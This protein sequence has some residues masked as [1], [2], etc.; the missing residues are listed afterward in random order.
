MSNTHAQV[1]IVDA[2]K[3]NFEDRITKVVNEIL[4][5]DT[6][7]HITLEEVRMSSPEKIDF[8][9]IFRHYFQDDTNSANKGSIK[10]FRD[11]VYNT[12][13]PIKERWELL[14]PVYESVRSTGYGRIPLIIARDLYGISDINDATIGELTKRIQDANKPGLYKY[15]LKDKAK[16]DLAIMDMGHNKYD[17]EYFRHVEKFDHFVF[18]NSYAELKDLGVQYDI[19]INSMSDY[20]AALRKAFKEGIDFGMVGVKSALA[21]PRILKFDNVS[22]TRA[23]KILTALLNKSDVNGSDIKALQDYFMHRVLDL[24]DEFDIPI[25][26]HTGIQAGNGGSLGNTKPT[27]LVNLFAEY[28]NVDFTL[29]HGGYPFGGELSVLA[30]NFPNV[31]IDMSWVYII[32]PSY[33]KRYLHQWIETV[34]A[35]KILGFGGDYIFVEAVYAHA[36]IARQIVADVLIEKVRDRYLTEKE[37]IHIANLI[38]RENAIRIFKLDKNNPPRSNAL[39]VLKKP[40]VIHDWWEFH[41]SKEGFVK[42]WKVIG[43]FDYG[44][45]LEEVYAPENKIQLDKSYEGKGGKVHWATEITP[46]TGHLNISTIVTERNATV[47]PRAKGIIYAYTE[48]ISPDNRVVKITLGSNDGAKIWINNKVIY[49]R[50]IGRHAMADDVILNVNLKKGKNKILIKV[51]NLGDSWGLYLRIVDPKKELEIKQFS[52]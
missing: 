34:P 35:N 17:P 2:P 46:E 14:K 48:V 23:E 18:V 7:E 52:K 49:N 10:E 20:L 38:L 31:Y 44:K 51:E 45:G 9:H 3:S 24:I 11:I 32:S 37:A 12:N 30:K 47:N 13:F 43:P 50:S 1:Q 19:P 33:S 28:P 36:V 5:V 16:I 4:I 25:Q 27:H 22:K 8:T 21:Y 6:H 15:I 42:N 26:Y 41:N 40:G 39:E 29:F